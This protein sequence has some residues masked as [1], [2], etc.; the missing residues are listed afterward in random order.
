MTKEEHVTVLLNYLKRNGITIKDTPSDSEE[1]AIV[2]AYMDRSMFEQFPR[3]NYDPI[4]FHL[5]YFGNQL[6]P[7]LPDTLAVKSVE[8]I[9][10]PMLVGGQRVQRLRV[11]F[12]Y[13]K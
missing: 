2:D 11:L 10:S 5:E 1:Q 6:T 9:T 3:V 4:L 7:K 8:I 13:T 12:N